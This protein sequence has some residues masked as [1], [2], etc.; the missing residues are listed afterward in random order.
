MLQSLR[1]SYNDLNYIVKIGS[2]TNLKSAVQKVK[3]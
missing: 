1:T 3:R 2:E